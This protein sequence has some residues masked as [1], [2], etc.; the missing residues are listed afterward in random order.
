[1]LKPL[2]IVI[3]VVVIGG[4]GLTYVVLTRDGQGGLQS[5]NESNAISN[6]LL[7]ANESEL[8]AYLSGSA[9]NCGPELYGSSPSWGGKLIERCVVKTQ[10]RVKELT[11]ILLQRDQIINPQVKQHWKHVKGQ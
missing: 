8:D 10:E 5:T 4:G 3:A 7:T 1:M 2:L 11:G 9:I 6:P